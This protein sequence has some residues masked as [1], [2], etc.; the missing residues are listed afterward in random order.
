MTKIESLYLKLF[1]VLVFFAATAPVIAQESDKT[2]LKEKDLTLFSPAVNETVKEAGKT[3][4]KQEED[5]TA[6]SY[7]PKRGTK[8]YNFEI[9]LSPLKPSIFAGPEE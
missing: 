8:E 1:L 2:V 5:A 3:E 4:S 6:V 9:G 7:S